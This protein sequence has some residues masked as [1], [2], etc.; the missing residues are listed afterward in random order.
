MRQFLIFILM[1]IH[2]NVSLA[3]KIFYWGASGAGSV[4]TVNFPFHSEPTNINGYRIALQMYHSKLNWQK[5]TVFLDASYANWNSSQNNISIV[6][7]APVIR[8]QFYSSKLINPFIDLSVGPAYL[9]KT[10]FIRHLGIH[11]TF[12]D[13]VGLGFK[14]GKNNNAAISWKI[15]HYSNGGLGKENGGITMPIVLAA[16]YIFN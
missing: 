9:S 1:L 5:S 10:T 16:S 11:Y 15:I 4:P 6:A 7:L 12:Q 14:F 8:Y 2:L 13:T 3:S